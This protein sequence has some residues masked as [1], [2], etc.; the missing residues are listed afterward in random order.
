VSRRT[1][2]ASAPYRPQ[3]A[4]PVPKGSR[5][6]TFILGPV[7]FQVPQTGQITQNLPVQVEDDVDYYIRG[8]LLSPLIGTVLNPGML[9]RI[10][11]CY[12][13]PLSFGLV[14]G[15]GMWANQA[16]GLG[17]FGWLIEPEIWCPA[18][19]T[20]LIDLQAPSSGPAA[21]FTFTVAP[22]SI[23]FTA[24]IAGAAGNGATITLVDPGAPSVPL[25]VAVA[26]RAVTVTL[27]TDGGSAIITTFAQL[28]ALINN[29]VAA[30]A[31]MFATLTGGAPATVV[32]ALATSTLTGGLNG[33]TATV[34]LSLIGVKR[35]RDCL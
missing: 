15:M 7:S 9:C 16:N 30:S 4:F 31:V 24:A 3:W 8:I 33:A 29:S 28:Q 12:G 14:L 11:D 1:Y 6:R 18:G 21:A 19:G 5:D 13:N 17:A 35:Y 10:R 26:G 20:L 32:T 34:D 22:E 27:A 25:S 2:D 23:T